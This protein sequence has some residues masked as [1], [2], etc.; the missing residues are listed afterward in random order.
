M[1]LLCIFPLVKCKQVPASQ[2]PQITVKDLE[3]K[4]VHLA[5]YQGKALIVNFWATWCGPCREEIPML[6]DLQKKYASKNLVILGISTDEEGAE[7]VKPFMRELP[8]HYTTL[9]KGAD[10]EDKFGG[11]WAYPTNFFYD[12]KGKQTAKAI[13]LQSRDFFEKQIQQM[14]E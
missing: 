1:A 9:L 7:V 14:V 12:K 5:D 4:S 11:I 10:T 13:G 3:G 2:L 6:N 8:I